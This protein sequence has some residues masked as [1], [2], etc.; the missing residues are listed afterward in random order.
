M[1]VPLFLYFDSFPF[2]FLL[3]PETYF[4]TPIRIDTETDYYIG[5]FRLFTHN[6]I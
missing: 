1:R 3:Q 2:F 5:K 6:S 4:C